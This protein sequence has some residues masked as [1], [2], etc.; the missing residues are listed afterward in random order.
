MTLPIVLFASA[1]QIICAGAVLIALHDRI[2][3]SLYQRADRDGF[4]K[5]DAR[6]AGCTT[7]CGVRNHG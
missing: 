4:G 7:G 1:A 6:H 2:H 3:Q 5:F